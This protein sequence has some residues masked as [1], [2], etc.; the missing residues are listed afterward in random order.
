MRLIEEWKDIQGYEGLYQISNLGNVRN[1]KG[2]LLKL[3]KKGVYGHASVGLSKHGKSKKHQVHRLVAIHFI[4]NPEN[5]PEVCHIENELNKDGFLNNSASNLKWGT[6][7]ENCEFEN[8][9]KRQSVNHAD[10]RGN[11]NPNYGKQ[12]SDEFKNKLMK[13]R[14]KQ[15]LQW[16]NGRVIAF[17]DSLKDAGRK[18][19]ISWVNIRNVCDGKYFRAG[20]YEW[21]YVHKLYDVEKVVEQIHDYFCKVIDKQKGDTVPFDILEYNKAICEIVRKGGVE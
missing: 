21:T 13:E 1:R 10:I 14:G 19:G 8:T 11:K 4:P 6:H 9:R 17:Y 20:G 7:K 5:K 3:F 12:R 15:V 2:N 18:T 16:E